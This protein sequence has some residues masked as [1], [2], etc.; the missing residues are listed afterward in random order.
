MITI[1]CKKCKNEKSTDEFYRDSRLNSGFRSSCKECEISKAR[2]WNVKNWDRWTHNWR[3]AM[4]PY[5]LHKK[6]HCERCPFIPEHSVQLDVHHI[7]L[8][9]D[10]NDPSNLMTVCANCH[11]MIHYGLSKDSNS[12]ED[13]SSSAG[14][15]V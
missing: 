14:K 15:V 1:L 11:R 2:D 3:K 7:D 13:I 10:N 8:N 6:D 4:K 9:H 12:R 5:Q